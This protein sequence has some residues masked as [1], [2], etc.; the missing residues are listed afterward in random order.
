MPDGP[1]VQLRWIA[2]PETPKFAAAAA[3]AFRQQ[4]EGFLW[5]ATEASEVAEMRRIVKEEGWSK[6]DVYAA[7]YWTKPKQ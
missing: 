5:F 2:A 3:A 7:T 4:G 6:D 1:G